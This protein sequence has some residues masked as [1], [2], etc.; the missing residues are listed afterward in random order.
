MQDLLTNTFPLDGKTKLS[1]AG[2]FENGRKKWFPL[3]RKSVSTS[4]KISPNKIILFQVDRKSVSTGRNG[5]S[6]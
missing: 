1:V 4:R 6:V 3:P 2:V 5:E